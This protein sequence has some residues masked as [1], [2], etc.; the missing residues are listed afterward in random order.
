MAGDWIQVEKRLAEKPEVV[1]L[2]TAL[3]MT[4]YEVVGH[5][6]ALW[7]WADGQTT[8]GRIKTPC[9]KELLEHIELRIV[10]R[11]GFCDALIVC[12][13]LR[14]EAGAIVLPNF[15]RHNGKSAKNRVLSRVRMQRYRR[16]KRYAAGVTTLPL[17]KRREEKKK[18]PPLPPAELKFPDLLNSPQFLTAW[19]KWVAYRKELHKPL[20]PSTVA[21]QI[22]FLAR[23]PQDAI[24]I[25]ETSIRS[26]W[27]G[28]FALKESP[29]VPNRPQQ[30]AGG[31]GRATAPTEGFDPGEKLIF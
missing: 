6:V 30:N 20:K 29:N 9:P 27:T 22:A 23:Q 12:G 2:Q 21:E 19:A 8:T 5:L 16:N 24:A 13:W 10:T 17:E 25:I 1:Y 4:G 11:K 28:L 7:S 15:R 31:I 3:G 14:E 18:Q 26:G